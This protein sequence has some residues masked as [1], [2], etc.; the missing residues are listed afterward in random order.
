[1]LISA[2]VAA[3]SAGPSASSA[4]AAPAERSPLVLF[5]KILDRMSTP[6]LVRT[7]KDIGFDGLDLT[8]RRNGHVEPANTYWYLTASPELMAMVSERMAAYQGRWS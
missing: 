8:V 6:E 7:L 5:T 3:S 4:A 2:T 1:M